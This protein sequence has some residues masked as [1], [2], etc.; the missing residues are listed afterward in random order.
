MKI[1]VVIHGKDTGDLENALEEVL[2][3]VKHGY[4]SGFDSNETG[5]YSFDIVGE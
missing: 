1:E 2:E 3:K 4:L 5:R